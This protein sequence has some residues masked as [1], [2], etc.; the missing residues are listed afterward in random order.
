MCPGKFPVW[1]LDLK[2]SVLPRTRPLSI[3][4]QRLV[5]DSSKII[6][7]VLSLRPSRG[8]FGAPAVLSKI[9]SVVSL[10]LRPGRGFVVRQVYLPY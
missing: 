1:V 7:V 4:Q 3:Q 5:Q 8:L 10:D 9:V 6:S 2:A